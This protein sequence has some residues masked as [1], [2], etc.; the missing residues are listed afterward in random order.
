M[1]NMDVVLQCSRPILIVLGVTGARPRLGIRCVCHWIAVLVDFLNYWSIGHSRGIPVFRPHQEFGPT[2]VDHAPNVVDVAFLGQLQDVLH[3]LPTKPGRPHARSRRVRITHDVDI[4]NV[5]WRIGQDYVQ[6]GLL[7]DTGSVAFHPHVAM[8]DA[9]EVHER[10]NLSNGRFFYRCELV[11]E[12]AKLAGLPVLNGIE[13][14]ATRR[15]GSGGPV[16]GNRTHAV[17]P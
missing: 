3:E 16:D 14:I 7:P 12:V 6:L 15:D 17:A 1:L 4:V 2:D 8:S 9:G 13:S 10:R 11:E 5:G